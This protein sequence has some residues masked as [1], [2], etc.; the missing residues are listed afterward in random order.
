YKSLWY[1]IDARWDKQFFRPLHA[2]GYYL[3]P[4]IHYSPNFK[5]EYDVKKK[6]YNYLDILVRDST[7]IIIINNQLEN[8]KSKAKSFGRDVAKNAPKTKT[9]SQWWDSYGDEHPEL[10]KYAIRILSLTCSSSRCEYNWS[11]FET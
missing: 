11:V 2:A 10:Q 4:Q 6:F 1:I 9:L 8:F 5:V 7:L 3:N